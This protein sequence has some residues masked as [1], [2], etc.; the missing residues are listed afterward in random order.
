MKL[1][2]FKKPL[3]ITLIILSLGVIIWVGFNAF[4][5]QNVP[6]NQPPIIINE[7]PPAHQPTQEPAGT[8]KSSESVIDLKVFPHGYPEIKPDSIEKAI[9]ILKV[10]LTDEQISDIS[11]KN[12]DDLISYHFSI[13]RW[14]RNNFGLW[15]DHS[16]L[17]NELGGG[18]PDDA[19][20]VLLEKLWES[21]KLDDEAVR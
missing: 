11:Q 4:K 8:E 17:R 18:H 21:L 19:S 2:P 16:D 3:V 15:N 7:F 13:G 20:T 14:I 6:N 12:K 9:D 5:Y 10:V 1:Q